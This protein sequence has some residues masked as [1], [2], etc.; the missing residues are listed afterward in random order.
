[1]ACLSVLA[2][3]FTFLQSLLSHKSQEHDINFKIIW[4]K[5]SLSSYLLLFDDV[6]L[7]MKTPNPHNNICHV[8]KQKSIFKPCNQELTLF[9]AYTSSLILF[10]SCL[11]LFL[12]L[13]C[14]SLHCIVQQTQLQQLVKK[15]E[16]ESVFFFF[17]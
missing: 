10:T 12:P 13:V 7:N 15:I 6:T 9:M 14:L 3:Q 4:A 8:F 17:F 5:L 1:M 11:G 2:V 16:G